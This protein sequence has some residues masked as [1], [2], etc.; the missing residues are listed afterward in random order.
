[1]RARGA[2][3]TRG[4]ASR[5]LVLARSRAKPDG[6]RFRRLHLL[7][8][9]PRVPGVDYL[10]YEEWGWTR[11]STG[12]YHDYCHQCWGTGGTG[13]DTD[14]EEEDAGVDSDS[15]AEDHIEPMREEVDELDGVFDGTGTEGMK[16]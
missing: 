2:V 6:T 3:F 15:D 16:S 5:V 13:P 1:M 7:G 4:T 9:C 14:E 12:Q 10:D 8:A 11:P